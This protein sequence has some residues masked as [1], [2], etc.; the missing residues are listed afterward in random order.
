MKLFCATNM[1]PMADR[2]AGDRRFVAMLE[3]LAR[4]HEVTLLAQHPGSPLPEF[5]PYV[6]HLHDRA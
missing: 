6:R 5:H 4:R 1:V 2:A 3:M